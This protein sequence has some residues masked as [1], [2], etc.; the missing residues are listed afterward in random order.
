MSVVEAEHYC[1][2]D[3]GNEPSANADFSWVKGMILASM[4]ACLRG[5]QERLQS[6]DPRITNPGV[7]PL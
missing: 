2:E 7:L 3:E 4:G 6:L 1:V 5:Y